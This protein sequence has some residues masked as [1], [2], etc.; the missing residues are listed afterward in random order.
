MGSPGLRAALGTALLVAALAGCGGSPPVGG[1]SSGALD[2]QS[3]TLQW[4]AGECLGYCTGTTDVGADLAGTYVERP[5]RE[6]A[7]YPPKTETLRLDAA[8]WQNIRARAQAAAATV[9]QPSYGCPDCGD[10]G[11]WTL[12][13]RAADG[14]ERAT[15]LDNMRAQNPAALEALLEAVH[16]LT[17]DKPLQPAAGL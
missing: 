16:G 17:P 4:F 1:A 3:V 15:M 5:F 2:V 14:E 7:A 12:T 6:D 13:V 11:G 9:W 8:Q 10:W